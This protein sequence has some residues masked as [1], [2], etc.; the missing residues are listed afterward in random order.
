MLYAYVIYGVDILFVEDV[1]VLDDMGREFDYAYVIDS[2][3]E[4]LTTF[5]RKKYLFGSIIEI[6]MISENQPF[7]ELYLKQNF[8]IQILQETNPD[9]FV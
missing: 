5:E 3:A 6:E 7:D 1:N 4:N 2:S 8:N 9:L